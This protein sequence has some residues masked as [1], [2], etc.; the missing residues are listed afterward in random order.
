MGFGLMFPTFHSFPRLGIAWVKALTFLA[1]VLLFLVS[2]GI[3]DVDP[4]MPL[5]CS[6]YSITTPLFLVTRGLMG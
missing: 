5:H 6:Y 1:H 2:I 3:L 4:T